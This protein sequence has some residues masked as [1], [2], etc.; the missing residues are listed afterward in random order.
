MAEK[1]SVVNYDSIMRNLKAR[2]FSPLYLL[3]GDESYYIDKISD[4]IA[5][6][7]LK[8]EEQDF[9]LS[10]VFGSD[11][12]AKQI[13]D[14]ALRYPMMSEF[15]VVI[16][17]ESQNL[18]KLEAIEKY[19]DKQMMKS[20]ILV[21]CNKNGSLDR[22]KK[23]NAALLSKIENVGGVVFE[24]K[25][26]RDSDLPGFINNY[27][28]TKNVGIDEKSA[29]MIADHIGADLSRLI[30][31]LDK[32]TL[33]LPD[34][35]RRITPEVVERQI[36]ISKDYNAY[37]LRNALINRDVLKANLVINY[38][39]KNPKSGSNYILI[40]TLFSFFQNLMIAYYSPNRANENDVARFLDL[41]S[42]WAAKDY[43]IGMR[44][45]SGIKTMQIISK[46]REIDAKMKGLD[47]PNTSAGDLMKELVFFILH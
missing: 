2:R 37:E 38:F 35:D 32:V 14:M 20:T 18:K 43:M 15:Q 44:N 6:N 4:Y 40:P 11:V 19:V 17:K 41:K 45:F 42:G 36:G 46:I 27:L 1:K 7:V 8:P 25:K 30:S 12:T 21:L 9:N 26:M 24:S 28:K 13:V 3:M 29:H 34:N 16:V 23:T 47:N 22:R 39:D 5:A 10:V 31:E 33:S